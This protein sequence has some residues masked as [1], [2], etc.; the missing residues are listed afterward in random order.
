MLFCFEIFSFYFQCSEPGCAF[1]AHF[2]I[3]EIHKRNLHGRSKC[4]VKYDAHLCFKFVDNEA[5]WSVTV[6]CWWRF[7]HSAA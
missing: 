5:P 7:C 3:V 4:D 2:K 6:A 1:E